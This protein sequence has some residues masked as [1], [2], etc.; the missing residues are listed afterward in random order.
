MSGKDASEATKTA[1]NYLKANAST[2]SNTISLNNHDYVLNVQNLNG[3]DMTRDLAL[4]TLIALASISL[5]KPTI[6]S[7]VVLGTITIGGTLQRLDDLAD[8]LQVA[9]DSGAKKV[10]LPMTSAAD[11]GN[12]PPELMSTFSILFYSSVEDAVFKALGV[13]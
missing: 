8:T 11:L 3:Y 5:S 10:L 12:V 2:I 9:H 6:D 13:S 1:Y 7:L 4:S